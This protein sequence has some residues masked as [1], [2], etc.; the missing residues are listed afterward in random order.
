[1]ADAGEI[2]KATQDTLS[3]KPVE[4]AGKGICAWPC[5]K[6]AAV[7]TL[8]AC[9]GSSTEPAACERQCCKEQVGPAFGSRSAFCH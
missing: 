2:S 4:E 8:G 7:I 6:G 9:S 1:M 5:T 3:L